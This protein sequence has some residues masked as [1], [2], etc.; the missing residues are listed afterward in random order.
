MWRRH[1]GYGRLDV[2]IRETINDCCSLERRGIDRLMF[3]DIFS[4]NVFFY[5][6][7]NNNYIHHLNMPVTRVYPMVYQISFWF[8]LLFSV[9]CVFLKKM[10]MMK[11]LQFPSVIGL[12]SS[13]IR[14]KV[15]WSRR[16]FIEKCHLVTSLW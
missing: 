3:T 11:L 2:M 14:S 13:I 4:P 6:L 16:S 1:S 15:Q 9:L 12:R 7:F 8:V 10:V 5:C